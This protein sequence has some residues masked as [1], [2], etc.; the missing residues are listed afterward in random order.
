[1]VSPAPITNIATNITTF[2]LKNPPNA[3]AGVLTP[4]KISAIIIPDEMTAI[5][6]LPDAKAMIVTSRITKVICKG[7]ILFSFAYDNILTINTIISQGLLK[8]QFAFFKISFVSL[9]I[10]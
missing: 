5:G 8:V 4:V 3:Y 6:I 7:V 10:T 1:M 2:V 9:K